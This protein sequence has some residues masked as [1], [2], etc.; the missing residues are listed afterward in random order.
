MI[1]DNEGKALAMM[2][3]ISNL[4]GT[5]TINAHMHPAAYNAPVI[6]ALY[7]VLDDMTGTNEPTPEGGGDEPVQPAEPKPPVTA[8]NLIDWVPVEEPPQ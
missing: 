5:L 8:E 4:D 2:Q 1:T 3:V 6:D 7:A